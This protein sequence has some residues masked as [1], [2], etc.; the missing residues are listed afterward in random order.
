MNKNNSIVAIY[1]SHTA[2]EAAEDTSPMFAGDLHKREVSLRPTLQP[3]LERPVRDSYRHW[4][5]NE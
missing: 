5:I 2:A 3:I 4:G 1:P